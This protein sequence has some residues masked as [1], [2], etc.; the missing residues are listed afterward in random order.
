MCGYLFPQSASSPGGANED[1]VIDI[2]GA[3]LIAQFYI[4]ITLPASGSLTVF[5]GNEQ[6]VL[7]NW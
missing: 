1:G 5:I 3:L 2:I 4:G 6:L 7:P